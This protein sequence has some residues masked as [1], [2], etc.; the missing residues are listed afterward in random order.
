[1]MSPAQ[2]LTRCK[3]AL[4]IHAVFRRSLT[5]WWFKIVSN[6]TSLRH[7][8][9]GLTKDSGLCIRKLTL[10]LQTLPTSQPPSRLHRRPRKAS[11]R[12]R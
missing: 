1:M 6:E 11:V 12:P 7:R 9:V 8:Q 4:C 5:G 10:L 3:A 2:M